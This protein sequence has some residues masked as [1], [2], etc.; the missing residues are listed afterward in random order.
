MASRGQV[1]FWSIISTIIILAGATALIGFGISEVPV[2][3]LVMKD[4][5]RCSKASL[6]IDPCFLNCRKTL[7]HSHYSHL[8]W[9][10]RGG[11]NPEL[12]F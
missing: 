6:G 7:H 8:S 5:C 10:H 9:E 3:L 4:L 11:W 12:H 2:W 1:I